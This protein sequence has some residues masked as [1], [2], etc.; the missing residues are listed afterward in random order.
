MIPSVYISKYQNVF[1]IPQIIHPGASMIIKQ[2]EERDGQ[3][4]NL[5]RFTIRVKLLTIISSIIILSL[6]LMTFISTRWFRENSRQTVEEKNLEIA[7]ITGLKVKSEL[8]NVIRNVRLSIAG[9]GHSFDHRD[10]FLNNPEIVFIGTARKKNHTLSI[11]RAY[12]NQKFLNDNTLTRKDI[13]RLHE[14]YGASFLNSF[15]GAR[16]VQNVSSNQSTPILG[17]SRPARVGEILLIFLDATYFLKTFTARKGGMTLTFLLNNTGDVI[18]H[19]DEKLILNRANLSKLGIVQDLLKSRVNLGQTVYRDE[20]GKSWLGAYH[21]IGF[22]GLG[23]ITTVEEDRAFAVVDSI[24]RMNF[25]L[26]LI[27]LIV[28]LLTVYY[29]SKTLTTPVEEL[30]EAT[31]QVERGNYKITVQDRVRDEIGLL[32]HS[33]VQMAK[34]L[35]ERER[36]KDALGRFVN[37]EIAEQVLRDEIK[38][39]GEKIDNCAISFCDLRSFTMMSENM[40]PQELV[41]Y[42]NEYFTEMVVCV[43]GT[44]GIVD[45]FIG[46][47]I[48]AHWGALYSRGNNTENAVNAALGMRRALLHFNLVNKLNME[49]SERP[50][51]RFGCGIHTGSVVAG[52]VG[53]EEHLEFTVIGDAVN[54]AS[55][56]EI[57]NKSFGSDIL[58]SQ[59]SYNQVKEIFNVCQM[60]SVRI[61]GKTTP[62]TFYAVLGRKDDPDCPANLEELRG[63]F[64]IKLNYEEETAEIDVNYAN[65]NKV[66]EEIRNR[67]A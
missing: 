15:N 54:L 1:L 9:V 31:R 17:A 59:E 67:Q 13:K 6:S 25:L 61:K 21:K 37:R 62:Q 49:G 35:E 42:L 28:A 50:V 32:S 14:L 44:N 41:K 7:R 11:S 27:F 65:I 53:S 51:A 26:L 23:V 58:I 47:A 16:V 8:A 60:P 4:Y 20:E 33:F 10:F 22:G 24:Q 52:Q 3:K 57:F 56:I 34:G 36:M 19:P 64:G 66:L 5:S 18:A 12:Y 55:R 30:V 45:K 40:D 2:K 29:Y 48:M 39:G 43:D 63:A 38:L 46:D